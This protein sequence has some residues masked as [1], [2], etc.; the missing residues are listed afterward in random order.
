MTGVQTCALPILASLPKTSYGLST[1]SGVHEEAI[2]SLGTILVV[3]AL[4]L[5]VVSFYIG[6]KVGH[7]W[8]SRAGHLSV[9]APSP[10]APSAASALVVTPTVE[11]PRPALNPQ[12]PTRSPLGHAVVHEVVAP[13]AGVI[14]IREMNY[15]IPSNVVIGRGPSANC[16]HTNA[17]CSGLN[18][19]HGELT[20]DRRPCHLC[21]TYDNVN[22]GEVEGWCSSRVRSTTS[23]IYG[24]RTEQGD[25]SHVTRRQVGTSRGRGRGR[26]RGSDETSQLY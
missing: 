20:S 22:R 21:F 9:R 6:F 4:L 17:G 24:T 8:A 23:S 7:W 14:E 2:V 1:S 18:L 26:A 12:F 3:I 15:M 25:F 13:V 10:G 11:E 5:V 19:A 16:Y